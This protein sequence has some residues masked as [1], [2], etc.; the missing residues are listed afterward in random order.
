MPK[1]LK[2]L[3]RNL[4]QGPAT[5]PFPFEESETPERFRGRVTMDPKLCVG[6]GICSHVCPGDAIR[7]EEQADHEGYYF[8]IWHNS[9]ALCGSCKHYCPTGAITMSQNWHNAHPQKEKYSWAEH[10]FV[11]YLKCTGCGAPIRMLPPNLATRIYAHSPVD[12]T[13]ILKL[14]PSCRQLETVKRESEMQVL[15]QNKDKD[16]KPLDDKEKAGSD[17]VNGDTT[18]S[19]SSD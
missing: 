7:I 8:A 16:S 2:V 19:E 15:E 12:M 5:D 11:P 17:T 18:E 14:C 13:E 4:L 6:C 3:A 9:C 1:F 10:H